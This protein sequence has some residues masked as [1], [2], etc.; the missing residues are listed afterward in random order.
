MPDALS[1]IYTVGAVM[2]ALVVVHAGVQLRLSTI[3]G[4]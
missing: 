3:R 2:L 1:Q 4:I